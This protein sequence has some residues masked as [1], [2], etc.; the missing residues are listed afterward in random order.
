M[1]K[2]KNKLRVVHIPQV[3]MEGFVVEVNNEREAFLVEQALAKQHLFLYSKGII[4][5][6]S[7]VIFVEMLTDEEWEDYYNE[8]EDM[9]WEE[10]VEHYEDYVNGGI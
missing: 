9:N 6:Y 7:N 8:Q 10:F 5:D 1:V 4:P 2:V 3:P